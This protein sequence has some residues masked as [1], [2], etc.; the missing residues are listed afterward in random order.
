MSVIQYAREA[1]PLTFLTRLMYNSVRCRLVLAA[2]GRRMR[3]ITDT[4]A[5]TL[6]R[7]YTLFNFFFFQKGSWTESRSLDTNIHWH[8]GRRIVSGATVSQWA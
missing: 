5:M 3:C 2:S 1:I 4:F 8:R 7:G 6:L